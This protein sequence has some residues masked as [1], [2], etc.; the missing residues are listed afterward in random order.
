[1]PIAPLACKWASKQERQWAESQVLDQGPDELQYF[2]QLELQ[3]LPAGRHFNTDLQSDVY[4]ALHLHKSSS[5]SRCGSAMVVAANRGSSI[6]ATAHGF[7][8]AMVCTLDGQMAALPLML[9]GTYAKLG[10][11]SFGMH[12]LATSTPNNRTLIGISDDVALHQASFQMRVARSP[13]PE[14]PGAYVH[15][16]SL[17]MCTELVLTMVLVCVFMNQVRT[18]C[19]TASPSIRLPWL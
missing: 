4:Q 3:S 18:F 10:P 12:I 14:K 15:V 5:G 1:M 17:C 2:W 11:T 7:A 6:P 13:D 19:S 16:L 9:V 8:C